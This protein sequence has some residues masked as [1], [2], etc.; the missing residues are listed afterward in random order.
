MN[1]LRVR[2]LQK[3][4]FLLTTQSKFPQT[5]HYWG[6]PLIAKNQIFAVCF[7][8]HLLRC[9]HI[10]LSPVRV[11]NHSHWGHMYVVYNQKRDSESPTKHFFPP[12]Q[13]SSAH[14]RHTR[15][16]NCVLR[17]MVPTLPCSFIHY[18]TKH[19]W[20]S[21]DPCLAEPHSP[22]TSAFT[23]VSRLS[24]GA[25]GGLLCSYTKCHFTSALSIYVKGLEIFLNSPQILRL[26]LPSP[27]IDR[28][29]IPFSLSQLSV[30]W[31]A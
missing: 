17:H 7:P 11:R 8:S 14:S 6:N 29:K 1:G 12:K 20:W 27:S 22:S 9:C 24:Q 19:H 18:V 25:I 26:W 31:F 2:S 4:F 23:W 30:Q 10:N 15:Q 13:I 21:W 28:P 16:L 3:L 5:K